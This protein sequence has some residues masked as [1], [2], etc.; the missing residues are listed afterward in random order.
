MALKPN[1]HWNTPKRNDL[2]LVDL[3]AYK[4]HTSIGTERLIG[5]K[6]GGKS[7]DTVTSTYKASQCMW[8][9][10]AICFFLDS[11]ELIAHADFCFV[12]VCLV[13]FTFQYQ[14]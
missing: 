4:N 2:S 12:L 9:H 13:L 5:R 6:G 1:G 3:L 7:I 11:R 10:T 8:S 14:H